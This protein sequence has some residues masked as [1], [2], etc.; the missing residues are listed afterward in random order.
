MK[1]IISDVMLTAAGVAIVAG[2]YDAVRHVDPPMYWP[3]LLVFAAL[4]VIGSLAIKA[5]EGA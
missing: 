5:S 3:A 1:A 4:L 2:F